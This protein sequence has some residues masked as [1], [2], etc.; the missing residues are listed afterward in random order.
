MLCT[1]WSRQKNATYYMD[2]RLLY[3]MGHVFTTSL[4]FINIF[5][6]TGVCD[7]KVYL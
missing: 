2:R 5:E 3:C 4:F 1:Q 7:G 6:E